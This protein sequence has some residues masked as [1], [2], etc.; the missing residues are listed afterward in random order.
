[1]NIVKRFNGPSDF[2]VSPVASAVSLPAGLVVAPGVYAFGGQNYDCMLEGLYRFWTPMGATQN[3][4]VYQNDVNALMSALAWLHVNGRAD[5]ALTTAQKTNAAV[6][7]KLRM[8]CGKT[9]EWVKA[10]CDS[11]GIQCRVA[12]CLTAQTPTNYYDGHVMIEVKVGGA[13]KLFDIANGSTYEASDGGVRLCDTLPLIS[14]VSSHSIDGDGHSV[15]PWVSGAF[16][17]T[18]W[19]E[20]TMRTPE[21]KRAELERVL[22]IPGIDHSDGL[23]YFYLPAGMESASSYVTGLSATYRVVSKAAWDSMFYS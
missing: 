9:I 17:V 13:W 3:R 14:A 18:A 15:E 22:Q 1:M 10:I 12:R 23:T 8:L 4:I 6:N 19:I 5:E 7:S 20:N 11:L 2:Q 16:D 21:Q